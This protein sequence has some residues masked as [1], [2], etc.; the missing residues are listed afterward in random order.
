VTL[1]GRY[2]K[3]VFRVGISEVRPLHYNDADEKYVLAD[4]ASGA[5]PPTF[6]V[7]KGGATFVMERS[8]TEI[9]FDITTDEYRRTPERLRCYQLISA[10]PDAALAEVEETLCE[11]YDHY[12]VLEGAKQQP[13]LPAPATVEGIVQDRVRS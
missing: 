2:R 10:M 13:L 4:I 5:L 9:V 11:T 12:M 1:K 7:A 8:I 3:Q 6:M